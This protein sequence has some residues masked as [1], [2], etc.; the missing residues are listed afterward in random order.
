MFCISLVVKIGFLEIDK[1]GLDFFLWI[2]KLYVRCVVL[3]K[4]FD[5][6]MF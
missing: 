4:F 6:F 2:C 1:F 5:V 3:G